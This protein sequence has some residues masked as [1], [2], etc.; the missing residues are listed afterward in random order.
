MF[1][2][3]PIKPFT[4]LALESIYITIC[5]Y[6]NDFERDIFFTNCIIYITVCFY[7]N[8]GRRAAI[9]YDKIFTLQYVSI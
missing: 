7:L 9:E 5:F 6:L 4:T 2:F 8:M 3:K 1:L